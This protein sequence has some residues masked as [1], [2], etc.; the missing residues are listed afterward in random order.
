MCFTWDFNLIESPSK[1][2]IKNKNHAQQQVGSYTLTT[3][4]QVSHLH[5][6]FLHPSTTHG[7]QQVSPIS[8]MHVQ[9]TVT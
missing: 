6:A 7:T 3:L 5:Y 4:S 8:K 9:E 2:N 1:A